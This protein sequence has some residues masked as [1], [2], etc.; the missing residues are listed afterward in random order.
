MLPMWIRGLAPWLRKIPHATWHTQKVKIKT[1][2]QQAKPLKTLKR[3]KNTISQSKEDLIWKEEQTRLHV[4]ESA[5]MLPLPR[6]AIVLLQA[7]S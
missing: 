2:Q 6:G 7:P 4:H 1:K 5:K 3:L